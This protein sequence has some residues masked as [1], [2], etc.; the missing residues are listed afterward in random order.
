MSTVTSPAEIQRETNPPPAAGI[1]LD[2]IVIGLLVG[3]A[4][5]GW[6]LDEV[7]VSVAWRLFPAAAL[8]VTGLI[9]LAS[10]AGGRGRAGLIGLGAALLV[11]ACA[12]GI[13]AD[14]FAGPVGDRTVSPAVDSWPVTV[15]H[16]AGN[17]TID[18]SRHSL[19]PTGRMDVDL[20]AGRIVL[21]VPRDALVLVEAQVV[22]GNI[23]VDGEVAGDGIDVRWS[24]PRA[25]NVGVV[26]TLDVCVGEIEVNHE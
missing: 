5:L 1:R 24:N 6:L 26:V 20:G 16:G 12:V 23:R 14:R 22:T 19:P 18:L 10:V 25:S 21:T 9:L 13:G 7:G 11:I 3:A 15:Q 17:V 8:V 4:G 2:R